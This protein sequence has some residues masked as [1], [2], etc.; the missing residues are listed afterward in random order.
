LLLQASATLQH[1]KTS[2]NNVS[3]GAYHRGCNSISGRSTPPRETLKAL[4][5]CTT[6]DYPPLTSLDSKG[7]Y[8]GF[9]VTLVCEFGASR[10]YDVSFVKTTWPT[11]SKDLSDGSKCEMAVGGITKTKD[12]AEQ[13]VLSEGFLEDKKVPI[14][15]NY[16]AARFDSFAS[17]NLP[18]V[19]VLE[20]R[21]GT[22]M[23]FAADLQKSGYL[24][25]PS[26]I[27]LPSNPGVYACLEQYVDRPLVMF[28]DLIEA[29]FRSAQPGS[30]L[31]AAGTKFDVPMDP[32]SSKVFMSQKNNIGQEII[33][34]FDSFLAQVKQD[35]RF[36]TWK[37]EAF[38]ARYEE[39]ET[40][41][42]MV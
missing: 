31:S 11:L 8:S 1:N 24:T 32:T 35:G 25:Q 41:C 20:N 15:S 7:L 27:I 19:T 37:A 36:E 18:D 26:V 29:E 30:L 40:A 39:T 2:V 14:F 6:G 38:T 21:G 12:R 16:N 3:G 28:T 5:V 33:N 22:N 10:G 9:D 17:F 4:K 23:A 13:F 42:A 34:Q